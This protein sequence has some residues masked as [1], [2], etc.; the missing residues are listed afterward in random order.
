MPL[1]KAGV[2]LDS[3]GIVARLLRIWEGEYTAMMPNVICHGCPRVRQSQKLQ[4]HQPTHKL[5]VS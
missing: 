3:R 1:M 4:L 5:P 2:S